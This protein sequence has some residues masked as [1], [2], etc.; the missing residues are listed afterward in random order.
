MEQAGLDNAVKLVECAE[1]V[2]EERTNPTT[3]QPGGEQ[4]RQGVAFDLRELGGVFALMGIATKDDVREVRDHAQKMET[5]LRADIG[6]VR[7]ELK[8][9]I[10]KVR[11]ELKGDIGKVRDELKGDMRE[12]RSEMNLRISET[13]SRI[14]ETNSRIDKVQEELHGMKGMVAKW[15]IGTVLTVIGTMVAQ[16]TLILSA[17]K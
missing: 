17:L 1:T 12:L 3:G 13:N 7:D 10:S 11:D 16:T 6:K 9:D 5:S 15:L 8:G 2:A 4:F 14:S